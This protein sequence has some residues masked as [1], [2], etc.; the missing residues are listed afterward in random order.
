MIVRVPVPYY[1]SNAEPYEN[2]GSMRNRGFEFSTEYLNTAGHWSYR[3][4]GNITFNKNNVISLGQRVFI[5]GGGSTNTIPRSVTRTELGDE[6]AFFYGFEY[7]GI[8]RTQ[9]QIEA[10]GLTNIQ[11]GDAI[12]N[13]INNDGEIDQNDLLKIGSP[14]P[15]FIY[16]IYGNLEYR[17]FDFSITAIGSYGNDIYNAFSTMIL[18]G[19]GSPGLSR[20]ALRRYH[21]VYNP[22][23]TIPRMSVLDPNQNYLRSSSLLLDNGS[24]FKIKMIQLGFTLPPVL[25][26]RLKLSK[27]RL[28]VS[29]QNLI[30][31]TKYTGLD[32]EITQNR[33]GAAY[34]T[35]GSGIDE[36]NIP[37]SRTFAFGVDVSF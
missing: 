20:R 5:E 18:T 33:P 28:Y 13:D 3:A 17:G 25:S 31:I 7:A 8:Y 6:V 4:G 21:P 22:D 16:S 37:L 11:I 30:T 24:Y 35:L 9:E 27:L 19:T 32:P 23:G 26:D 29:V 1:T 36:M 12:F 14:H 34:S 15:D 10:S 2:A